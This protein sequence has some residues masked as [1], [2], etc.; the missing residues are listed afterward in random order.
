[1]GAVGQGSPAHRVGAFVSM[2]QESGSVCLLPLSLWEASE[3]GILWT[4]Q[5][6]P[7]T[8]HG[9]CL[10]GVRVVR[11]CRAWPQSLAQETGQQAVKTWGARC[12]GGGT[13]GQ[14]CGVPS[15]PPRAVVSS[16]S[17]FI[18]PA[19]NSAPSVLQALV[20]AIPPDPRLTTLSQEAWRM[21]DPEVSQGVGDRWTQTG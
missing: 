9:T 5:H 7:S 8:C 19:Q 4:L 2:L 16:P 14:R 6:F 17:Y 18:L 12:E 15:Q 21:E 20:G 10:S 13:S 3:Q 11:E 1:M